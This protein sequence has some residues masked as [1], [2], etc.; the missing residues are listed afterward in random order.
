MKTLSE[1]T[2]I[3][4]TDNVNSY[5]ELLTRSDIGSVGTLAGIECGD[6]LKGSVQLPNE[7][8]S[9]SNDCKDLLQRLLEYEPQDRIRSLFKLQRIAFYMGYNFDDVK[10][11]KVNRKLK[12]MVVADFNQLDDSL[13]LDFKW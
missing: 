11:K 6:E 3:D 13:F 4:V 8:E 9:A 7:M 12:K 5:A 2:S 10:K 1:D